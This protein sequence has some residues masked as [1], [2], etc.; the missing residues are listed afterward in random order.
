MNEE[1]LKNEQISIH[2]L[3]AEEVAVMMTR[4]ESAQ[5]FNMFFLIIWQ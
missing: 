4:S 3:L 2:N 1:D 5:W